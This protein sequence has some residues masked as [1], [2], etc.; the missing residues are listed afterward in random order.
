MCVTMAAGGKEDVKRDSV[1]IGELTSGSLHKLNNLLQGIVGLSELLNS[2]P[3][4]PEEAKSD[5]QAILDIAED[6]SALIRKIR[7]ASRATVTPAPEVSEIIPATKLVS[8]KTRKE[9]NILVAEDDPLV[10]NVVTGMLK[11]LG[12][13]TISARDG[14]EAFQVFNENVDRIGLVITDMV[15]P[16]LGGLELT[17]KILAIRPTTK[18]VVMTG[19]LQ[20]D[21][22]IDPD[23]FGLSGWLEK[24]MTAERLRQLVDSIVKK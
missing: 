6:A 7:E 5:A 21:L 16:L 11:H 2:N 13:A 19:Y 22:Q 1:V 9:I 14:V 15:M 12:Y 17:A 10:L 3:D 20:E 23:E 18:V 24:P 8:K 4:L